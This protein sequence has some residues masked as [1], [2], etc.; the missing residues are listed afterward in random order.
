MGR[1]EK[2]N[3]KK[4]TP[5]D[6]GETRRLQKPPKLNGPAIEIVS[7]AK[8]VIRAAGKKQALVAW[9]CESCRNETFFFRTSDSIAGVMLPNLIGRCRHRAT[10]GANRP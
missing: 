9:C 1:E 7:R 5:D 4:E 2:Q 8:R 3:K 6:K 10:F